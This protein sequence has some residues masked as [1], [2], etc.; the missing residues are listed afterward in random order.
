MKNELKIIENLEE[1]LRILIPIQELSF[2]I[3][4]KNIPNSG[5]APDFIAIISYNNQCFK[6]MGEILSQKYLPVFKNKISKLK[7]YVKEHQGC[8]SLIISP[9]LSQNKR[10]EC[11]NADINFIDLSG[12]VFIK[13]DGLYIERE[14][15]PNRFPEKRKGRS[16]FSDKR[17]CGAALVLRSHSWVDTFENRLSP[18]CGYAST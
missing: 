12:N 5:Q 18:L 15:F 17:F 7:L 13:L 11:K 8:S 4:E 6:L 1:N 14:G 3:E 16:L 10:D 9:Y 2:Y